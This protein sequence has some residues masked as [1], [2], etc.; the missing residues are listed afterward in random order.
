[1]RTFPIT[2]R[3][4]R[5]ASA[6]HD[7][8]YSLYIVGG[9]VRDF[10]LGLKNSDLDFTTDARPEEVVALFRTVIPTG[11]AH[12][13]V[14]VIF[15]GKHY[16]VTTF[17]SEGEYKDGRRPS[18]VTFI[19]SLEEDLK[20]RDFTI[21]AFAAS[22][23]TGKIIYHHGGGQDLKD[24]I[25]RAI[26][27]PRERFGEDALRIMRAARFSG[28]LGFGIEEETFAAMG[29]LKE[30][31]RLV[32]VERI[33]DELVRLIKSDHPG[34]GLRYLHDSG[35][36]AVIL[37]E[38]AQGDGV[39]QKGFHHEDVLQHS[40]TTCQKAADLGASGFVR[41]A[42]LFHDI[43]KPATRKPDGDRFSFHNHEVAGEALVKT[44][45]KRLKASNE[46]IDTV[47][48]LVRHHMFS[49]TPGMTDSAVR[50]FI[51]RVGVEHIEDLF[52]LRIADQLAIGGRADIALLDEFSKRIDGIIT[53]DDALSIKD[54]AIGGNDLLALG[55]P[56]GRR[57]GQT[58]RYLLETV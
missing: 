26:G 3:I 14:T 58:L 20:R 36:L 13:T 9:A 23:V 51:V 31:L 47:S 53:S 32:S 29:A 35:A 5:F 16:E 46:E 45:L 25:I 4:K 40:F 38:L 39:L 15:E 50:R 49:Y 28:K 11:I 37:P 57:I 18:S 33:W 43:G 42:A 41:L 24:G 1:M 22:A 44:I 7:N 52:T 6:F 27:N 10:L 21:N 8:G 55:I 54:L 12:G 56:K 2:G 34:K 19:P 30:N 17:R 48:H